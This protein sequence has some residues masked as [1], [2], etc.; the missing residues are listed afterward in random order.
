[1][2]EIL[3][4]L[5]EMP[6]KLG[7]VLIKIAK[8]VFTIIF[9]AKI[10]E[11]C[12]GKYA[13]IEW[14]EVNA[15]L[16]FI[17]SGRILLCIAFYGIAWTILFEI[18]PI[19]SFLPLK[20]LAH[21]NPPSLTIDKSTSTGI[22][23]LLDSFKLLKVDFK[24]RRIRAA[25][26]TEELRDFVEDYSK[27]ETKSEI[28]SIK[29]ALIT[30][31]W[32]FYF[33]FVISYF[34]YLRPMV[35]TGWITF[36]LLFGCIILPYLYICISAILDKLHESSQEIL[37]QLDNI[38]IEKRILDIMKEQNI[39]TYDYPLGEN[40]KTIYALTHN[41]LEYLL[42]FHFS[43]FQLSE[44]E[45]RHCNHLIE[46]EGKQLIL[47]AKV[48]STDINKLPPENNDRLNVILFTN[49]DEFLQQLKSTL[50]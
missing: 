12:V 17:M 7:A 5:M 24:G 32:H 40:A 31:V 36:F 19:I 47:V 42:Y 6:E 4:A 33:L 25:L 37:W 39:F 21:K 26:Y 13:Y 50:S 44:H 43:Q 28:I 14:S 2:L 48:S 16:E 35:H 49:E 27:K 1:M 11:L 8:I 38:L 46:K 22:L 15:W 29:N 20:Y 30:D 34:V 9:A 45:I 23:N 10:Y 18:L 3:K 41:E